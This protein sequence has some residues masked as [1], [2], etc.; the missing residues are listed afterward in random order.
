MNSGTV[1]AGNEGFTSMTLR[2]AIDA[3]DRRDIAYKIVVELFVERGVDH[4]IRADGEQRVALWWRTHDGLSSDIAAGA[5]P[6]LN[7][8]LL[9]EPLGEPLTY[10]A[11]DDVNR[12][13][14]GKS[15]DDAHRPRRI[16]LRP[17]NARHGGQRGGARGQVQEFAA[18]K[19]HL[20]LPSHYSITS[21]ARARRVAGTSRPSALAALRLMISSSL[22]GNSTGK[23]AGWAPLN[24]LST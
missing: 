13:A 15:N 8:E 6:I 24:I 21:S 20:N 1:L 19:F 16:G 5:R 3:R 18:G 17:C 4:I 7:D 11:R 2:H 12:M 22:V 14:R 9:T 23:S 10:Y